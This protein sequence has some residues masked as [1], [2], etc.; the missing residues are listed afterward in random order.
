MRLRSLWKPAGRYGGDKL[1]VALL[2]LSLVLLL[3]SRFS[4]LVFLGILGYAPLIYF[5][6]RFLSGN[7]PKRYTELH[8][9]M[10]VYGPIERFFAA[11]PAWLREIP[12][13]REDKKR[14]CHFKC[15]SCG[16]KLRVPKGR[17]KLE[18]TCPS[19][20]TAFCKKT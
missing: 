1:G 13:R 18:I 10:R 7:F 8:T 20:K 9:F 2:L 4:G 19:C 17:G 14:N 15:P 11:I 12:A 3:S 16:Q 5:V 6:F